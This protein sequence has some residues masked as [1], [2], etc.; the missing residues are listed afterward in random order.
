[1]ADKPV[2]VLTDCRHFKGEMPCAPH[3]TSAVHCGDCPHYDPLHERILIIKL[4][5]IGDVI[6]TTPLLRVIKEKYPKSQISWLTRFPEILPESWIDRILG[7]NSD[8]LALLNAAE[9]DWLINLDKDA[10]A[11]GLSETVR[12]NR[13]TGFTLDRWGR[14]VPF[15][16][17]EARKKWLTG[18]WDDVNQSN[19]MHYM[20][21]I[22]RICGF[23]FKGE[24]Y[25]LEDMYESPA[26]WNFSANKSRIGLNTGCGGRWTSRLWPEKHWIELA[27]HLKDAGHEVVLLGGEQEHD[28]N[29]RIAKAAGVVYPGH[30]NLK[31]FIHLVNQMDLVVTAVTMAM[32]VAI[33]L[34]KKLVLFNNIFNSNEFY[35]YHRGLI[36]A[37]SMD[38]DCYFS[39]E[40]PNHCMES[41]SVESVKDAVRQLL[42]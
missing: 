15:D 24:E 26:P 37:P 21:E 1:M 39:P 13:K 42:G 28:K 14:C 34:K 5:A 12:A 36:L 27:K 32:H 33:G 8:A 18:I 3:K 40:C 31:T 30:Y 4:G 19:T 16:E 38:C 17:E 7:D 9:F 35:L 25:I 2:P 20:E 11:I 23:E 6:R 10:L 29:Q 22:F 41:L